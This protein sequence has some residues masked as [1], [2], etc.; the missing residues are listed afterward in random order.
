MKA[1]FLAIMALGVILV[2]LSHGSA[3]GQEHEYDLDD[4]MTELTEALTLTEAQVPR[5]REA[6][7]NYLLEL[8]Q[9]Q[10]RY[11][12]QEEPNPQE[13]I[14][15]LKKVRENYY[16]R[17]QDTVTTEQWATY[18]RL[19]E[20]ILHEIFS[21]I[22]A[23][24]IIDLKAP[25]KLTEDQ[26]AAMKPVMGRSLR[27]VMK[28]IFEYGDKRLGVRTKLKIATALK[29]IKARQDEDMSKILSP[30]QIAA[31]ETLKEQQKSE[32]SK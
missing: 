6:L 28:V 12:A 18:E 23:L 9:T 15:D 8:D 21:E 22:A 29:S 17:M 3:L 25:L 5:V 24:R 31:W 30:E 19:R 4:I 27:E 13:M 1:L 10:A 7:Q 11:D 2:T 14:G 26:M 16:K 20:D 32:A